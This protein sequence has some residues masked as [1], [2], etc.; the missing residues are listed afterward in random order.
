MQRKPYP[1]NALLLDDGR[2]FETDGTDPFGNQFIGRE[3]VRLRRA[4]IDQQAR[5]QG[6]FGHGGRMGGNIAPSPAS[7]A[8]YGILQGK[9]NV[10]E[11]AG[12]RMKLRPNA[13]DINPSMEGIEEAT[14]GT[15]TD[16]I[17]NHFRGRRR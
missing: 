12:K 16:Q 1:L 4:D 8:Y 7:D 6:K 15:P 3:Q 14:A 9:Q 17:I 2:E 11:R 5:A 10:A 13:Y